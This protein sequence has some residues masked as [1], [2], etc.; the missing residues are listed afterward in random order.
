ML[1]YTIQRVIYMILTLI[2]IATATFFLMKLLPG[3]PFRN[4]EKLTPEQIQMLNKTYNLDKPVVEQYFA[5]MGKVAKGDF[6]VSFQ[7]KNRSVTKLI[8]T[9]IGPSAQ[10][11]LQAIILGTIIGITLGIAAAL[12]H[13]S[14]ID[15]GATMI[16]V[17]GVSIP[18]FVFAGLLQYFLSVK[19]QLFPVIATNSENQL[20][21]IGLALPTIALSVFVTSTTA[22]YMRTEM[23]EVMG[24]DYIVLAKAKGISY[25]NI[26]FKHGIRNALIP[27]ITVIGP[28]AVNIMT[29]SL[30]IERIFGIP[31]LGDQFVNSIYTNDYPTIM[32][33]TIFYSFLL[34]SIILIVDLLY[35]VID[36][37]IRVAGGN[38]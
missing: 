37:R 38:K 15:Y 29:G 33:T 5:Y 34:I 8:S 32:G 3:S 31:G 17:A 7:F 10:L 23:L 14:W 1:R 21:F 22:R 16:A 6:G 24:S 26:V 30:V 27:V 11:G 19:W 35:G 18:S 4:Q 12:R 2:V 20:T 36:P 25:F 13:N 28:M 9:R